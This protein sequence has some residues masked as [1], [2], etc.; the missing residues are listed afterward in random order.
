MHGAGVIEAIDR[1]EVLGEE[2]T[3]YIM[4]LPLGEMKVMVPL[5]LVEEI[6]LRYVIQDKEVGQVLDI[7]KGS[8]SAMPDNWN[9]RY[10]ANMDKIRKGEALEIAEVVRNLTA[11]DRQKRLSGGEKRILD[12][13]R[14]LLVG[15]LVLA[16]GANEQHMAAFL[17]CIL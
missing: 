9:E 5:A 3:Y 2:Q 1:R 15:E 8:P 13:A 12:A 14:Q 16:G 6:A 4:K 17:S 11:R 10:R 7:L